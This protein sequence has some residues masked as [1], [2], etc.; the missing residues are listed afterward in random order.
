MMRTLLLILGITS[1]LGSLPLAADRAATF[2]FL[3]AALLLLLL[4]TGLIIFVAATPQKSS[5]PSDPPVIQGRPPRVEHGPN[6]AVEA[7]SGDV[8]VLS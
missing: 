6:S 1:L 3:A 7:C 5:R 8:P 2:G 4:G